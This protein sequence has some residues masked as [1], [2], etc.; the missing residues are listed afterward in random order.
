MIRI[1]LG[2][3]KSHSFHT[4]QCPVMRYHRQLLQAILYD[5]V[6]LFDRALRDRTVDRPT[7][8]CSRIACFSDRRTAVRHASSAYF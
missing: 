1:G 8:S 6:R 5:K 3:A 2:W 4:G 7:P